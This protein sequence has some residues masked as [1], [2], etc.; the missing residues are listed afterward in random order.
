VITLNELTDGGTRRLE[1]H[2]DDVEVV[3]NRPMR[4]GSEIRTIDG[5]VF[6]VAEDVGEVFARLEEGDCD[7][8]DE[9]A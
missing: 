6:H 5:R 4:F 1:V 7:E 3:S 8:G 2:A 9:M